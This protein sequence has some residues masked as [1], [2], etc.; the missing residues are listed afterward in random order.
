MSD[1]A[2]RAMRCRCAH[3]EIDHHHLHGFCLC[4]ACGCRAFEEV[5]PA[6]H[7]AQPNKGKR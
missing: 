2:I 1:K 5:T 3:G 7:P 4:G 6:S